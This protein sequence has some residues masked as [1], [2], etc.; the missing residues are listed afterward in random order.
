MRFT[1]LW[2]FE[3]NV[4]VAKCSYISKSSSGSSSSMSSAESGSYRIAEGVACFSAGFPGNTGERAHQKYTG[5]QV[6][7][8]HLHEH[9]EEEPEL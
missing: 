3:I 1:V 2:S 6:Q 9:T 5:M 4:A 7:L 8:N